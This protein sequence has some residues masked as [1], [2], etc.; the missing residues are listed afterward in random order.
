M[1]PL[2]Y[3]RYC[4]R[5]LFDTEVPF[6]KKIWIL[7]VVLYFISPIDLVPDL[8]PGL[9]FLDDLLILVLSLNKLLRVLEEYDLK[10]QNRKPGRESEAS[11][12]TIDEVEYKVHRD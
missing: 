9:G 10:I 5:Y 6:S 7:L 4:F 11:G 12:V 8:I 2:R 1:G 3:L